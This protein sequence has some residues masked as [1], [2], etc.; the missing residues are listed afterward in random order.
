MPDHPDLSSDN[1]KNIVEYI[2]SQ[3][4]PVNEEVPFAKPSKKMTPYVPLSIQ[5]DYGFFIGYL[6]VVTI[7]ILALLFTVQAKNFQRRMHG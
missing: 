2:K 4:K 6:A 1:I 5:K 3:S 7:L